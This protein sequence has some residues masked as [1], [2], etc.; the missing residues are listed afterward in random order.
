MINCYSTF[1]RALRDGTAFNGMSRDPGRELE[2]EDIAPIWGL[3]HALLASEDIEAAEPW[4]E[5][6]VRRRLR[7]GGFSSGGSD[8]ESGDEAD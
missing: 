4:S 2:E 6:F 8:I 3:L 7:G 5:S 1:P